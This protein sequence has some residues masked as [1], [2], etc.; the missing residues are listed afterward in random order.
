M[1]PVKVSVTQA[2]PNLNPTRLIGLALLFAAMTPVNLA[3]ALAAPLLPAQQQVDIQQQGGLLHATIYKPEGA[4]PFPL[5]IAAHDC[6]GLQGRTAQVRSQYRD[7]AEQLI[8]A[9]YAVMLPDSYGSRDLGP[10][11]RVKNS[12]V[13]AAN[14]RAGDLQASQ[15]WAAGQPWVRASRVSLLGWGDGANALLSVVRL[16]QGVRHGVADFRSAIAFYPDC[17]R[18][19]SLGWSARVPTLLLTGDDDDVNPSNICRQMI[20][21]TKGRSAFVKFIGYSGAHHGFDRAGI[22]VQSVALQA[23]A[24]LPERGHVGTNVKARTDAQKRVIRWLAR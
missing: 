17:A 19:S 12:Q 4:G 20:D 14:E 8:K 15:Q 1:H 6:G 2:K 18:P 11:C 13:R 3:P 7:W 16:R 5:V 10:Q 23:D 9:G 22:T 21:D 24:D